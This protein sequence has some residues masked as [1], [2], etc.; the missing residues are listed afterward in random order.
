MTAVR[1]IDAVLAACLALGVTALDGAGQAP[2]AADAT[3]A[4]ELAL[5]P[6]RDHLHLLVD[7]DGGANVTVQTG[8]EGVLVVD[9]G[10]AARGAAVV[11]AVRRLSP[12]PIRYVVNTSSRPEHVGGN[13]VVAAAGRGYEGVVSLG[14]APRATGIAHENVMRRMS[15]AGEASAAPAAGWP[16]LTFFSRRKE[17]H[18]NG[19]TVQVLYQPAA[20]G[21]GDSIVFFR[22]SDVVV[23]GD[24]FLTT[25]YPPIDL[26]RGGSIDG[27][28]DALNA[29]IDLT[30]TRRNQEG[31]TLVVPGH[32][33][34]SD[35]ADVVEYRDMLHIIRGRIRHY[36]AE[37]RGLAAIQEA[38]PTLDYDGRYGAASG[39]ASPRAFVEI[40]YRSVLDGARRGRS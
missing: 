17:L 21:D 14:M 35:E 13:A 30:N 40:V 37:G 2:A 16:T 8:D 32:G 11:R 28:I 19:E 18:F 36:V 10:H 38:R 24:I 31:G 39:P 25:T 3:D 6:V 1:R 33:R 9:T 15:G 4:A 12:A 23:A 26:D 27:V 34:V 20:Q 7:P 22:R 29:V 5:F